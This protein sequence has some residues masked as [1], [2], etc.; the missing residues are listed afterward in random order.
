MIS[1]TTADGLTGRLALTH[2]PT[3]CQFIDCFTI[4]AL[5]SD[6]K[7]YSLAVNVSYWPVSPGY[8][9]LR[10]QG[11]RIAQPVGGRMTPADLQSITEHR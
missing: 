6:D 8:L 9:E 10:P 7:K 3:G 5:P 2:P 4:L 1:N 11:Q